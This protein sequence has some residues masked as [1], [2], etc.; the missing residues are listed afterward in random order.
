MRSQWH[1]LSLLILATLA[2]RTVDTPNADVSKQNSNFLSTNFLSIKATLKYAAPYHAY[3]THVVA[4]TAH[5]SVVYPSQTHEPETPLAHHIG[6]MYAGCQGIFFIWVYFTQKC[7]QTLFK[8]K[9]WRTIL[10]HPQ[11]GILSRIRQAPNAFF[12]SAKRKLIN[13]LAAPWCAF[14]LMFYL[15]ISIS[16]KLLLRAVTQFCNT[17]AICYRLK[18]SLKLFALT[19]LSA[20][21]PE[22]EDLSDRKEAHFP[23][24]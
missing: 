6:I 12:Q 24:D 18:Y 9:L 10:L 7:E 19:L 15:S 17:F 1:I 13:A 21:M 11:L 20:A 2:L 8:C 22:D 16:T 5:G 23:S 14:L 4:S 3:Y